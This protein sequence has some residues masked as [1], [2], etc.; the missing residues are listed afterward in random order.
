MKRYGGR[1]ADTALVELLLTME[2]EKRLTL[3][4]V[5]RVLDVSRDVVQNIV[6]GRSH[7]HVIKPDRSGQTRRTPAQRALIESKL[8]EGCS[9][10]QLAELTEEQIGKRLT[11][12]DVYYYK[13][14]LGL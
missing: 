8:R 7:S 4:D 3:V 13:S 10:A 12:Q 9:I 11:H 5:A 1:T 14:K 2:A 6:L